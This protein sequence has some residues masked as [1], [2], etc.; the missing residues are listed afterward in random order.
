MLVAYGVI[1]FAYL[2]HSEASTKHCLGRCIY[3]LFKT[4]IHPFSSPSTIYYINWAVWGI[5]I[6]L[7]IVI[8][9][10]FHNS[11]I[12]ILRADR[13]ASLIIVCMPCQVKIYPHLSK[14]IDILFQTLWVIL[15]GVD[16]IITIRAV[17][18]I[19][20]EY[21]Q[22]IVT[23]NI[24]NICMVELFFDVRHWVYIR[25]VSLFIEK[26]VRGILYEDGLPH[27]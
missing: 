11:N 27:H 22:M 13:I 8:V 6:T 7:L 17:N 24:D 5:N 2:S 26:V 23:F 21:H 15:T 10:R 14:H 18:R 3:N 12:W 19:M 4:L 9:L 20:S 16:C 1:L 25:A